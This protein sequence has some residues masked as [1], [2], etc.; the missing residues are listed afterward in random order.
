MSSI[1]ETNTGCWL[2]S[3][4]RMGIALEQDEPDQAVRV[5]QWLLA[6]AQ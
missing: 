2:N 1:W 6:G 4:H 5:A 3:S